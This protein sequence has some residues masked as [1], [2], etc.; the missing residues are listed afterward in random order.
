MRSA[1]KRIYFFNLS[2]LPKYS[3]S[4]KRIQRLKLINFFFVFAI[5]VIIINDIILAITGEQA[6]TFEKYPVLIFWIICLF[7]LSLTMNGRHAVSRLIIIFVPLLFVTSYS[8]TGYIIGE[9]FLWQPV[10]V[11]GISIV[12]YLVLDVNK[13]RKLLLFSFLTFLIYIIFHDDIMI[14]GALDYSI[15]PVFDRL[16]TTPFIYNAVRIIIFLFLSLIIYYSVRMND[17]QQ[18]LNEEVNASLQKTSSHLEKVNAELQA[19]RDA[20]NNSASLL[21]TDEQGQIVFVNNNFLKVSNF[22]REGLIGKKM[23]ELLIPFYDA[24]FYRSIT[25]TLGEGEVWRGELKLQL[26][27]ADYFWM[28][29]AISNIYDPD[30]KQDGFLAIMFNITKLKDDEE[31][32]ERLNL[33]KDRILYAVAHDLKNPL[34]NFKALLGLIKNGMVSKSEEEEVFRLMMKDCDHSTNL[35]AELLEI[36]RLEDDNFVLRK[37]LIDLH[38]FFERS[39]EQFEQA[40]TK[41]RIRF[42]KL[43]D[44]GVQWVNINEREFVR[45]AY[46]LIS[47]AV[48]FTPMGGEIKVTTKTLPEDKV[49]IE[50]SDTGVGISPNLLPIIFDKFSKAARVG[51]QGE[52]STGLGMWIVKHIVKLHGGEIS[53]SSKENEGTTFTIVLPR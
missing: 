6:Y 4:Q 1:F 35:I 17:H 34:L 9:H 11:L 43:F 22:A 14:Y 16:N 20:I 33:E 24:S 38:E 48:K 28:E 25:D 23:S 44:E 32:L 46:N 52:K 36:G 45:V 40:A 5:P 42:T 10:V 30:R 49:S 51:V 13:D 37:E 7:A 31:R 15:V 39:F 26:K 53:V 18:V 27:E 8:L 21:I 50:I 19:H 41:K 3:N 12:P 29:T 47:N 2:Q